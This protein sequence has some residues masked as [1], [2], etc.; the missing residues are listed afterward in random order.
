MEKR[1]VPTTQTIESKPLYLKQDLKK[2]LVV[3]SILVIILAGLF[4]IDWKTGLLTQL[5]EKIIP[6]K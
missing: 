2:L 4:F 5:A 3:F 6:K 1:K